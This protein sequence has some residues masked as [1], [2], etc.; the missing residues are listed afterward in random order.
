MPT[1]YG[2]T[3]RK[4]PQNQNQPSE[5][6]GWKYAEKGFGWELN[7]KYHKSRRN[8]KMMK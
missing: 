6:D 1:G 3:K 4:T 7:V 2:I 8:M 5:P